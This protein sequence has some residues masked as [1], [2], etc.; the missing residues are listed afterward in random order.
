M[1]GFV[2]YNRR[3]KY[4]QREKHSTLSVLFYISLENRIFLK[5]ITVQVGEDW[6]IGK[7]RCSCV[8]LLCNLQNKYE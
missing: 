3:Q 4:Y 5:F 1:H 6:P 7:C 2:F 8:Q